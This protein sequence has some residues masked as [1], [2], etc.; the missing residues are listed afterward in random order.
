MLLNLKIQCDVR[1][2]VVFCERL[3]TFPYQ[4][5]KDKV[6]AAL[7]HELTCLKPRAYSV[8]GGAIVLRSHDEL[9]YI[10]L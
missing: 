4:S 9:K 10:I 6:W 1:L 3:F 7:S 5:T 2:T 8:G